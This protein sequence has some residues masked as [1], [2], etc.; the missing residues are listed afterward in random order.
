[1]SAAL[2]L[3]QATVDS[4]TRFLTSFAGA[5]SFSE[6]ALGLGALGAEAKGIT[7]KG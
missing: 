3:W 1:M 4:L 6:K 2:T 7:Q 5:Q